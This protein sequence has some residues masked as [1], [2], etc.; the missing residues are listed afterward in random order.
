MKAI[1]LAG[2][3]A[4][5]LNPL[6]LEMPKALI[7]IHRRPIINYLIKLF[8]QYGTKQIAVI[9]PPV[10][11]REFFDWRRRY[12]F[13]SKPHIK[14]VVE[15]EPMGTFGGVQKYLKKWVGKQPF[16]LS[17]GD[18]L[19]KPDLRQMKKFH[20]QQ[21]KKHG[22]F[23]T[24]AL[25]K[26]PNPSDFGVVV[27][28]GDKIKKFIEKPANPPSPYISSGLYLLEAEIFDH[29]PAEQK[30]VMIE[31]DIFPVLAEQ[32]RLAGFKFNGP[33]FDCGTFERW[34]EAIKKWE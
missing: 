31:K 3:K 24:I 8:R 9:I 16:F 11:K 13:K 19:K 18:E 17:N 23:G 29:A 25:V 28:D 1:I 21:K 10:W 12:F 33:W 30:F 32:G 34:E 26:V 15:E 5:R 7:P 20:H 2:G 14:I 22:I 27:M 4:T 6:S